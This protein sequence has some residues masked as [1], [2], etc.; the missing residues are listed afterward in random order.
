MDFLCTFL[1]TFKEDT[2]SRVVRLRTLLHIERTAR[3]ISDLHCIL[4]EYI[5]V[6]KGKGGLFYYSLNDHIFCSTIW[7]NTYLRASAL[8]DVSYAKLPSYL[9]DCFA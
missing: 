7:P 8:L 9:R 5:K 2:V 3:N 4:K 6:L 1:F